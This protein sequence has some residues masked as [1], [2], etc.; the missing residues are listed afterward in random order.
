MVISRPHTSGSGFWRHGGMM[1]RSA[2]RAVLSLLF[3]LTLLV[4]A[5]VGPQAAAEPALAQGTDPTPKP[6]KPTATPKPPKPTA[7]PEPPQL[8]QVTSSASFPDMGLGDVLNAVMPGS[9]TDDH[10]IML[11]GVGSDLWHGPTDPPDE[12]WMVTDRG[13]RGQGNNGSDRQTFAVPEYT[14]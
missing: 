8:G 9:V 6:P 14:P 13:P 3:V 5:L 1:S 12:F 11:G 10:G 7:T 2:T 4:P